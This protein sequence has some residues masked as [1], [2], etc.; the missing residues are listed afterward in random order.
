MNGDKKERIAELSKIRTLAAE[1][2]NAH[3]MLNTSGRTLEE[4][5]EMRKE[6]DLAKAEFYE[7]CDNLGKA[8]GK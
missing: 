1:R 8:L 7:A 5:I 4:E 6:Y 2:M 3:G